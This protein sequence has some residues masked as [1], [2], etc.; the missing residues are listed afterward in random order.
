MLEVSFLREKFQRDMAFL[1]KELVNL[2]QIL[3]LFSLIMMS[4]RVHLMRNKMVIHNHSREFIIFLH[5]KSLFMMLKVTI[6]Q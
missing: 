4:K 6:I 2:K 1:N 5:L 3:M